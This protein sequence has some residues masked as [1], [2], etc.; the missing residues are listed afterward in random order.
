MSIPRRNSDPSHV[1]LEDRTFF[2]TAS[3][4]G[5]RSL[6]Q[7]DR[8]ARLFVENIFDYRAQRKYRLH[9]FVVMPDHFH[10]LITVGAGMTIER[11]VQLIKGGFAFRAGRELGFHAPVWQKGFSEIR[12]LDMD[13]YEAQCAYIWENPVRAHLVSRAEEYA[14]SSAGTRSEIDPPPQRL[15]PRCFEVA[16][17]TPEGVP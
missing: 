5:R 10:V 14:Y 4:W 8:A 7:S 13:A 9:E 16:Y 15:K 12:V 11:A 2:V 6:L 3:I 1:I 17:G